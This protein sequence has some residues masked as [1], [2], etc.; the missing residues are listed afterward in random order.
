MRY[1]SICNIRGEITIVQYANKLWS[2]EEDGKEGG[3]T[4]HTLYILHHTY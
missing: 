3:P 2:Y 4:Q 1:Y